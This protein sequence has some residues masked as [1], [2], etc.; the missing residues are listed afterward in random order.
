MN[1]L[2]I[3]L[4]VLFG[5]LLYFPVRTGIYVGASRLYMW[6]LRRKAGLTDVTTEEAAAAARELLANF[7][8]TTLDP[9]VGTARFRICRSCK[10]YKRNFTEDKKPICLDCAYGDDEVDTP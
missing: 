5:N 8:F 9:E 6:N 7:D 3:T 1:V 4:G 10:K 2:E